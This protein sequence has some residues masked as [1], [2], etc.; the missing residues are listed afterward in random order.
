[1]V[2]LAGKHLLAGRGQFQIGVAEARAF[3]LGLGRGQAG[4]QRHRAEGKVVEQAEDAPVAHEGGLLLGDHLMEELCRPAGAV[5]DGRKQRLLGA[6]EAGSRRRQLLEKAFERWAQE[7]QRPFR[8]AKAG[9]DALRA[10][11]GK[12]GPDAGGQR[13]IGRRHGPCPLSKAED[14]VGGLR[15]EKV[16]GLDQHKAVAR[17]LAGEVSQ[18]L[19]ELELVVEVVLEPQLD[20][21]EIAVGAETGVALGEFGRNLGLI[22]PETAGKIG[23]PLGRHRGEFRVGDRPLVQHVAPRQKGRLAAGQ[24]QKL[25]RVVAVGDDQ[26]GHRS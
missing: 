15:A 13:Q 23:D 22:N 26:V 9:G 25:H 14:G 24:P 18:H 3:E 11:R 1:M 19:D 8:L 12:V 10:R 6:A 16:V 7:R 4:D 21:V 20:G 5:G 2:R 17:C